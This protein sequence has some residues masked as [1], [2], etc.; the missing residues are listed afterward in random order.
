MSTSESWEKT[1]QTASSGWN[2]SAFGVEVSNNELTK[3]SSALKGIGA[4]ATSGVAQSFNY[5]TAAGGNVAG[6][7]TDSSQYEK[8]ADAAGSAA[9]DYLNQKLERIKTLW[10]TPQTTT[11]GALIGEISPYALSPE[12]AGKILVSRLKDLVAY[13]AGVQSGETWKDMGLNALDDVVGYFASDSNFM[14]AASQLQAI[15]AFGNTLSAI[16]TA[17]S[18]AKKILNII[19]T[20][21]PWNEITALFSL[22]VWSG[23]T[24]A[25]EGTAK[26]SEE[27]EKI[28]QRLLAMLMRPLRKMV[29]GIKLQVPSLLLGAMNSI[30]VK[31]AVSSYGPAA[32][33]L[34]TI[35]SEKFY[36]ETVNSY[37]WETGINQALTDTLGTI[38]NWSQFNFDNEADR[39]NLL[40]S[41]FL[42]SLVKNYM[43]GVDGNGGILAEAKTQAHIINY[44]TEN[45]AW[46]SYNESY[47]SSIPSSTS[48]FTETTSA[49]S[50]S[51][52]ISPLDS[53]LND[54]TDVSPVT[55]EI[56]IR[57]ISKKIYEAL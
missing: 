12:E 23:G 41:K 11:V 28:T 3:Y 22:I 47:V 18:T 15:Q 31:E 36:Q 46:G 26:I 37:R 57:V 7:F 21:L 39:G 34:Q 32:T 2:N 56:A 4:L 10:T 24:T 20:V 35:F 38:D 17:L 52:S 8:L 19:E 33:Y 53:I 44:S 48:T 29:F 14:T 40:K 9:L 43:Y 42:S 50:A 6:I 16:A 1:Q 54:T 30:S 25:A 13:I 51:I 27:V 49:A 5:L 45:I 55:D